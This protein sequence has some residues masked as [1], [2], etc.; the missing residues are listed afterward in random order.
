MLL[1]VLRTSRRI[2]LAERGKGFELGPDHDTTTRP[3]GASRMKKK[4]STARTQGKE[5]MGPLRKR[6]ERSAKTPEKVRVDKN[7][8]PIATQPGEPR[9]GGGT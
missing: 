5:L 3:R 8:G 9:G 1:A 4:H 2:R 7:S 6:R